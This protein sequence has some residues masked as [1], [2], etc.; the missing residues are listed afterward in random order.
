MAN[1]REYMDY[2]DEHIAIAPANSQEEAM[3]ANA[4]ADI[5]GDHN[6]ETTIEEFDAHPWGVNLPHI[7]CC[8]LFCCLFVTGFLDGVAKIAVSGTGLLMAAL[9]LFVHF[10][11][12]TLF[13][14]FGPGARS[15]NVVGVHRATGDKVVKGTRP[16]V[17]VA[18]Y[19]TPRVSTL[20]GPVFARFQAILHKAVIP[21]LVVTT[22]AMLIDLVPMPSNFAHILMWIVG[23]M[24]LIPVLVLAMLTITSRLG[25]CTT[26]SN[27][28]KSS[29]AAMLSI[30][31]KV[32]PGEDR[33][34]YTVSMEENTPMWRMGDEPIVEEPRYVEVVEEVKGVRHG[35]DVLESLGILPDTCEIIYEEPRVKI[36]EEDENGQLVSLEPEGDFDA[37]GQGSGMYEEPEDGMPHERGAAEIGM[38]LGYDDGQGYAEAE[39]YDG[40]YDEYDQDDT[41]DLE[42]DQATAGPAVPE[43]LQN[44]YDGDFDDA[45]DDVEDEDYE[46]DYDDEDD[47]DDD[48]ESL[49]ATVMAWF[50]ERAA[51]LRGLVERLRNPEE[52]EDAVEE[53]DEA[54]GAANEDESTSDE[55]GS[56]ERDGD[57]D[58]LE[59]GE[60]EDEDESDDEEGE[61][62]DLDED[63]DQ[64][65]YAHEEDLGDY[66]S[67]KDDDADEVA[68]DQDVEVIS[69]VDEEG[70]VAADEDQPEA[71]EQEIALSEEAED[72]SAPITDAEE[73]VEDLEPEDEGAV[74]A[75]VEDTE[76]D[77]AT[78]EEPAEETYEGVGYDLDDFGDVDDDDEYDDDDEDFEYEDEDEDVEYE[79]DYDDEDVEDDED[80]EYEDEEEDYEDDAD[81]DADEYDEDEYE[82]GEYED[83]DEDD[84]DEYEYEDVDDEEYEYYEDDEEEDYAYE[85]D[86]EEQY[87]DG[88]DDGYDAPPTLG[89]RI[90][91][92]IRRLRGEPEE[93]EYGYDDYG[94]EDEDED[95][96]DEAW[97]HA[98]DDEADDEYLDEDE[99]AAY[100]DDEYEDGEY[101]D[102]TEAD[103]EFDE[104]FDGYD[105]AELDFEE[106]LDEDDYDEADEE[107]PERPADPNL[108]HFDRVEDADIV[109]RDTTGLDTMS[110]SYELYGSGANIDDAPRDKPEPIQDPTWGEST[111]QPARPTMS[112]ARRAALFDL[113]D[114][115]AE[116][117]DPLAD[118]EYDD[119]D[120][121]DDEYDDYD[122]YDDFDDYEDDLDEPVD[123]AV[124]IPQP[125][126][127]TPDEAAAK[128]PSPSD[129][130]SFWAGGS[131]SRWKGGAALRS[132]LREGEQDLDADD[133]QDA[134][135]DLGDDYLVAHD[136]WFVA[137]G[138]SEVNHAGIRAFVDEHA[139]DLR[140]A[141]LVNLDSIGAGDLTMLVSEGLKSPRRAD[142]RLVGMIASIAQDLHMDVGRAQYSWDEREAATALRARIRAVTIA[143]LDENDL[144]TY[145]HTVDDV[146]QNVDPRSVSSVV[147]IV[148][149]LIRRS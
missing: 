4:I 108:L 23:L 14:G 65:D 73:T 13:D 45:M 141:F 146:P 100:G 80:I 124:P 115:S 122:E 143:G 110:D 9:M 34:D 103:D 119:Y 142:R 95:D 132:D 125:A 2:L 66:E 63:E 139:Q 94:P 71:A 92:F 55:S 5:F 1:T 106:E 74:A 39:A 84:A 20:R 104:E 133:M 56:D 99:D 120:A 32:R 129:T 149:E 24:A 79:D 16:I 64:D 116:T 134:I 25:E 83:E 18:H 41:A 54:A 15:Q 147:R 26:G 76:A 72:L 31:N 102:G 33:V 8:L 49:T 140:G 91:G 90:A 87:E 62:D 19:D 27:D 29:V 59:D 131:G 37:E 128:A 52:D 113:P 86:A 77:E 127:E 47:F 35:E 60:Y 10:R 114:P 137:T 68:E 130:G 148:T 22:I 96:V 85:Y 40:Q 81:V 38:A 7:L 144:P 117:I 30:L 69:I 93:D 57:A 36:Y 118:I 58:E 111:Y 21:C 70:E 17:I 50:A 75:S 61:A 121:P 136:I 145:S 11:A 3:A 46:E 51:D 89:E 105:D 43:Q 138:A 112:I 88:Y 53:D 67:S 126:R 135:L 48:G 12:T 107:E 78:I 44:V 42:G 28:N 101:E 6:L 98:W 109:E 123:D 82:D 97:Q